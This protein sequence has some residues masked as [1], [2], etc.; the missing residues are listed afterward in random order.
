MKKRHFKKIKKYLF[1]N[2]YVIIAA[3]IESIELSTLSLWRLFIYL[4]ILIILVCLFELI[5][6]IF[7][8]KIYNKQIKITHQT[9]T[10]FTPR[11][12]FYALK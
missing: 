1:A 6:H 2:L 9:Y 5:K 11:V 3:L 4:L 8:K 12:F 7:K 10:Y